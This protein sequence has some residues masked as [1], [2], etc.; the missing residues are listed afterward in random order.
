MDKIRTF[1]GRFR[2]LS[3]FYP[4]LIEI[5][6]YRF[7]T[8]EHAFQASKTNSRFDKLAIEEAKT[9]AAAKYLGR[10]VELRKDWEKVKI[11]EM[12]KLVWMKFEIPT[13][14][15]MLIRTGTS[16]LIEG[17]TWGDDYWGVYNGSGKNLSL[18][19]I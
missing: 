4:S 17:N 9:P 2:F 19:H 18:I 11:S 5:D 14:R 6:S 10:K 15:D 7:Q 3:N 16:E 12:A 8:V 13:L 1:R